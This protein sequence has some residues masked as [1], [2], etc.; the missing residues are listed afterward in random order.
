[1]AEEDPVLT[2]R[3]CCRKQYPHWSQDVRGILRVA[4]GPAASYAGAKGVRGGALVR[5]ARV[6]ASPPPPPPSF[7]P[8]FVHQLFPGDTLFG[9]R[10]SL[11]APTALR[12]WVREPELS[13]CVTGEAP[14]GALEGEVP[15]R[16]PL[17]R[18]SS[19]AGKSMCL[20]A[21]KDDIL[22][23]LA[24]VLPADFP[25]A[26]FS[27]AV[28]P[29]ACS[30]VAAPLP[31]HFFP[32]PCAAPASSSG[33]AAAPA[34]PW[35]P[36]GACIHT[37]ARG[38]ATFAIHQWSPAASPELRAYHGRLAALAMW[39]IENASA[40]DSSDHRWDVLSVYQTGGL[41]RAGAEEEEEEEEAAAAAAPTPALV[42]YATVYRF[43][44]P[45]RDTRPHC[46]RLAQLLCLP[47]FQRAG[48]GR[49]VLACLHRLADADGGG[50]G[51]REVSVEDPCEG[52]ARLRD[53]H[54]V[55]R[56][57]AL[58]LFAAHPAFA[59]AGGAPP[60]L[61]A[62]ADLSEAEVAGVVH[63]LRVTAPQ[64][65]RCY[66]ALLL[67]RLQLLG[68]GGGGVSSDAPAARAFRLLVKRVLYN[69]DADIRA[70]ADAGVRKAA[71]ERGFVEA[72]ASFAGALAACTPPLASREDAAAAAARWAGVQLELELEEEASEHARAV[73]QRLNA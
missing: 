52:M 7:V 73:E 24:A 56:A 2:L 36:P 17:D 58:G 19:G 6:G 14:G 57:A 45:M 71:L 63:A 69:A 55:A 8:P 54:D 21:G 49:E 33:A 51:V 27:T 35:T 66:L 30:P 32:T 43:T 37:Y 13:M 40:I 5:A 1:M 38:A 9:Y 10:G 48:H 34:A 64:A 20:R 11:T 42:G 70:V 4:V 28:G 29:E 41:P 23:L 68:G 16:L 62:I 47:R 18:D 61:E 53:A 46:L 50:E 60:P 72:V 3:Q 25:A 15:V 44:N 59:A 65:R 67:G 39:L 22:E 12:V 26:S 31:L